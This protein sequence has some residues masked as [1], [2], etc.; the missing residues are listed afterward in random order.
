M[1]PAP[2]A[3]RTRPSKAR[4]RTIPMTKFPSE[5]P[6]PTRQRTVSDKIPLGIGSIYLH[7]LFDVEGRLCEV[8]VSSPGRHADGHV[9][10]AL[11]DI[12][13]LVN[14]ALPSILKG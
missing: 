6:S 7:R 9:D 8:A 13:R 12:A 3:R 11:Q 5:R 1:L 10:A 14:D 4:Q 2:H